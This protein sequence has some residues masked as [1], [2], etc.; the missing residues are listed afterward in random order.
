MCVVGF[1]ALH[2]Y[3]YYLTKDLDDKKSGQE[4]SEELDPKRG[5]EGNIPNVKK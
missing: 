2:A 4:E 5:W 3:L 1:T